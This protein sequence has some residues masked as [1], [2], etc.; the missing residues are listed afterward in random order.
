MSFLFVASLMTS[1]EIETIV[2]VKMLFDKVYSNLYLNK[3]PIVEE[4]YPIIK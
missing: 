4:G 3:D 1:I 2:G